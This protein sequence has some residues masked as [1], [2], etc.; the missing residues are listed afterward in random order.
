MA[1]G[2]HL[3]I[4]KRLAG[5][6]AH[7]QCLCRGRLAGGG[8]FL[9]GKRPAFCPGASRPRR[10][11]EFFVAGAERDPVPRRSRMS[12]MAFAVVIMPLASSLQ[13]DRST[14][15]SA[16]MSCSNCGRPHQSYVAR[17]LLA[18][19]LDRECIVAAKDFREL[20]HMLRCQPRGLR[21]VLPALASAAANFNSQSSARL[22]WA[23][24]LFAGVR[25]IEIR[26]GGQ[27]GSLPRA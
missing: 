19:G 11:G 22:P 14:R 18:R 15:P 23:Q 20:C 4:E 25:P 21:A 9:G 27:P 2:Q 8:W 17:E 3:D 26:L 6:G 10:G 16:A 12:M 13:D 1:G 7:E 5:P 24:A